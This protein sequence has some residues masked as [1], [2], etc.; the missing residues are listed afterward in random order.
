MWR[1]KLN[2]ANWDNKE[3]PSSTSFNNNCNELWV[4]GTER[5]VPSDAGHAD[6]V[7]AV[8]AFP[9]LGKDVAK[10]ALPDH[11]SSERHFSARKKITTAVFFTPAK[12]SNLLQKLIFFKFT[13]ILPCAT[14]YVLVRL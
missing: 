3:G 13:V 5:T 14:K 10:L 8:F 9:H 1:E 12:C 6:V 4:D 11:T 7:D 2:L